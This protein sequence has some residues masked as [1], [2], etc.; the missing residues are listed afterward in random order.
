MRDELSNDQRRA[1]AAV[2][3]REPARVASFWMQRPQPTV[4]LSF[5]IDACSTTAG[6]PAFLFM[7]PP[8]SRLEKE[9]RYWATRPNGPK[10]MSTCHGSSFYISHEL[11]SFLERGMST[12]R[13]FQWE[14]RRVLCDS[15]PYLWSV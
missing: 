11:S 1:R 15:S 4:A 9:Q 12:H 10:T 7:S 2:G 6:N 13:C 5:P 3:A 8:T 14:Q